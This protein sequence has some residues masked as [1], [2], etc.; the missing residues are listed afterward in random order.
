MSQKNNNGIFK[1]SI[2]RIVKLVFCYPTKSFHIRKAARITGL[3][4]T[5]VTNAM[6]ELDSLGVIRV[7]KTDITTNFR[8]DLESRSYLHHKRI[9]NLY[10][11][12]S[13]LNKIIE[14]YNPRAVVLFGSFA[15]G[16][17]TE[18]SDV[19]ILVI[20]SREPKEIGEIHD[21]IK[22]LNRKLSIHVLPSLEESSEEF[23]NAVCNGVVLYGYVKVL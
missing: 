23:K 12:E 2:F 19:D 20:S 21:K 22:E 13:V 9:F 8:A 7:E 4:T 18:N 5:A 15:R 10:V 11:L 6:H 17:D 3:S 14:V 1:K 16:E